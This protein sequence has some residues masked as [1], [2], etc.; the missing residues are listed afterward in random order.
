LFILD[1][2]NLGIFILDKDNLQNADKMGVIIYG[3]I[4]SLQAVLSSF[5][6]SLGQAYNASVDQ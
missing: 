5:P 3:N 6:S 1:H 2:P 4:Q